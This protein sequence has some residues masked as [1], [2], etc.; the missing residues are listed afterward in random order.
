MNVG[1]RI[2]SDDNCILGNM[3]PYDFIYSTG[4]EIVQHQH[5]NVMH[6]LFNRFA[7]H[8]AREFACLVTIV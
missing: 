5:L 6:N 8:F 7:F 4:I 1:G 2:V 3:F